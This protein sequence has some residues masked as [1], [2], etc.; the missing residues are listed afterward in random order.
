MLEQSKYMDKGILHQTQF[1]LMQKVN[2]YYRIEIKSE[3]G[4]RRKG[5]LVGNYE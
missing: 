2:C 3:R 4:E 5:V 1:D